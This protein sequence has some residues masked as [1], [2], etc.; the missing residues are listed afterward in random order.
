MSS[1]PQQLTEMVIQPSEMVRPPGFLSVVIPAYNEVEI[2]RATVDF[3]A[4]SLE[5]LE[6][7]HEFVICENG[8]TD[9]TLSLCEEL[10]NERPSVRYLHLPFAN[11]G[12][13]LR[14]GLTAAQ[15]ETIATV[16]ADY[17]DMAFISAALESSAD[18]VVGSKQLPTSEDT[19]PATRRFVSKCFGWVTHH[20][21]G[22]SLSE[23]H[24]M[25]VFKSD[26]IA[27][28]LPIVQS[29]HDLFDTELLAIAERSGFAIVEIPVRTEE[30]RPSRSGIARRI[31]RTVWGLAKLAL[32][33]K[34]AERL[35]YQAKTPASVTTDSPL[36]DAKAS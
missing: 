26:A 6:I 15:S 11:Y 35:G 2:L 30:V 5:E 3:L 7:P 13:A 28:L 20:A 23:T 8:S 27:Q 17:Y 9:G 21:L 33:L 29:S 31:P 22:L 16:D 10:A 34:N 24:G 1:L 12:A 32:R 19:R 18:I 14:A 25:K 4:G 36:Q